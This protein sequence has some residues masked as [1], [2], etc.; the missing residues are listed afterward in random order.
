MQQN[1]VTVLPFLLYTENSLPSTRLNKGIHCGVLRKKQVWEVRTDSVLFSNAVSGIKR[2]SK[3]RGRKGLSG[4]VRLEWA[5]EFC[6]SMGP[7]GARSSALLVIEFD[8]KKFKLEH[9]FL[10]V[11]FY[12]KVSNHQTHTHLGHLAKLGGK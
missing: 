7:E 1:G 10:F 12:W 8:Y 6:A 3:A 4:L 11:I 5:D 2:W 9:K